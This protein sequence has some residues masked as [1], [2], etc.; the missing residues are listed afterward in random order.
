MPHDTANT[1]PDIISSRPPD[2]HNKTPASGTAG[3][4]VTRPLGIVLAVTGVMILTPDTLLMRI[5]GFDGNQMLAWRG[6]LSAVIYLGIWFVTSTEQA[7]AALAKLATGAGVLLVISQACNAAFF[8]IGIAIAPVSIVLFGVAT[9]PIFTAIFARFIAKEATPK[10]LWVATCLVMTGIAIAIFGGDGGHISLD[11]NVLIGG[12]LG[13]GVGAS[14]ALSLVLIRL[15]TGLPFVLAIAIGAFFS[16]V[17]GLVMAGGDV[18]SGGQL[19]PIIVTGIFVLPV[20]FFMLTL[21]ARY[22]LSANVS[23]VFL[24]ETVL[25]PLWV[26]WGIGE[27]PSIEMIVGGGIVV[28]TLTAYLLS[29]LRAEQG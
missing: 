29:R 6:L 10:T 1:D 12:L 17:Y 24:L 13:L 27:A 7:G 28:V 9:T 15:H 5:S 22:T 11:L 4:A 19:V 25:G 21:A 8:A 18:I 2:G 26:W 20:S 23:L 14:I 3:G 16:G